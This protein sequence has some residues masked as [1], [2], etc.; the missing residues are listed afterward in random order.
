M[1]EMITVGGQQYIK[2]QPLG[3]WGLTFLTLGIYYYVW[4]FKINDEARRYLADDAIKPGIALL[5]VLLGWVLIIPPF[6]SMYRTGERIQRMQG[7]GGVSNTISPA[8]GL[9][10][11]L[12]L[13]INVIYMQENLN[14]VWDRVGVQPPTTP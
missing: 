9:L 7:K 5:A 1:A 12:F 8:L 2:R 10:A 6:V 3:A 4:Y 13:A 11:S 14:R